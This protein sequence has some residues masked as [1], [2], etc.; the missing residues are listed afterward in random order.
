MP[1]SLLNTALFL[2]LT[3]LTCT[4]AIHCLKA[5]CA[6]PEGR[7]RDPFPWAAGLAQCLAHSRTSVSTCQQ[8]DSV[9]QAAVSPFGTFA[10]PVAV[11]CIAQVPGAL[12]VEFGH[13]GPVRVP[14][15][16]D[17]RVEHL[18]LPPAT[19]VGLHTDGAP[20][21]PVVLLALKPCPGERRGLLWRKAWWGPHCHGSRQIRM[22][23]CIP[24]G[25]L[26]T[27]AQESPVDGRAEG[28]GRAQGWLTGD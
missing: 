6:C 2:S 15:Q 4:S 28:T 7:D 5:D 14:D 24:E 27:G 13:Q 1:P 22:L 23:T 26:T 20:A 10:L 3:S 18:D 11:S 19:L 16:Q 21:P 9:N 25:K 12:P 17:G 8:A